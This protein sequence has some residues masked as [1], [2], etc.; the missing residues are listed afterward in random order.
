[1]DLKTIAEYSNLVAAELE[2]F[3]QGYNDGFRG[4]W[5]DPDAGKKY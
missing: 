5:A 1:M 4:E 3:D 2:E